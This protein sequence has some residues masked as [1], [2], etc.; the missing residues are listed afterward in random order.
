MYRSE[1]LSKHITRITDI[2][3]VACYLI[4]GTARACLLDTCCGYGNLKDYLQTLTAKKPFVILTHGHYDHTGSA[5]LFEEVYMNHLDLPVL[6]KHIRERKDFL[7]EDK[8]HIPSLKDIQMDGLNPMVTKTP[9]QLRNGD[10]FDLGGI[11]IRMVSVPGHT[12]GMMCA[13]IP[14]EETIFFGDACGMNVLLHDEFSSC[15]SDYRNSLKKLKSIEEEYT[16][17]YRN[18]GSFTNTKELLDNVLDC[19]DLILD[20]KDDRQPVEMFGKTLYAA[21]RTVSGRR[22]DGKEGNIIYAPEK[23]K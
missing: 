16:K 19:C 18:H 17:I 4:E 21:K 11:R 22:T 8:K 15:V 7:E 10:T 14:E 20:Q 12:P 6:R 2:A 1:R 13:L 9:A 5:A 3:G 23:A